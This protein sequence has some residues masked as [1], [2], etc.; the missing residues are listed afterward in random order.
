MPY[1]AME[2]VMGFVKCWWEEFITLRSTVNSNPVFDRV[3]QRRSQHGSSSLNWRSLY[4]SRSTALWRPPAALVIQVEML[5]LFKG[6][7]KMYPMANK[8]FTET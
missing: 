8:A 1:A 4:R 5:V 3:Y 6:N 2:M 7:P